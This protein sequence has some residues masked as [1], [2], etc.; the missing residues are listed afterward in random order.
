MWQ[1]VCCRQQLC[2][3]AHTLHSGFFGELSVEAATAIAMSGIGTGLWGSVCQELQQQASRECVQLLQPGAQASEESGLTEGQTVFALQMYLAVGP[4]N[5]SQHGYNFERDS[6]LHP[7]LSI[8]A[9]N[10][11]I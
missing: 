11:A 5:C 9:R 6:Y 8:G 3:P 10:I 2:L 7:N 1:N 4:D